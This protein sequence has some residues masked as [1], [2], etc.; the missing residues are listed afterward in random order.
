VTGMKIQSDLKMFNTDVVEKNERG[1]LCLL[2][3]LFKSYYFEIIKQ[4]GCYAYIS[5]LSHLTNSSDLPNI[6]ECY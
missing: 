1:I 2:H 3:F 6:S 4:Q 5:E